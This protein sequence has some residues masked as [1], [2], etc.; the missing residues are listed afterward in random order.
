MNE[1]EQILRKRTMAAG[2]VAIVTGAA[3]RIG[4]E[5][6]LALAEDGYAVLVHYGSSEAS[7]LEVVEQ[8][9]NKGGL[10]MT[11]SADLAEPELSATRICDAAC[12][13]GSPTLLINS[14][15]VFEDLPLPQI[16]PRHCLEHFTVNAIA[17]ILLAREFVARLPASAAGQIISLLDWRALHPPTDHLVYTASKAALASI[18]LTLAQ[19]LAPQI[20]V[21]GIALGAILAPPG[22]ADWHQQRAAE[23]I[24][25]RRHGTPRDVVSALRFLISNDFM[26]GEI[27]QLTG[28][29]HL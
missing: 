19:Q 13:L 22:R 27:L 2:G 5:I 11:V 7:A 18:T 16:S 20:R 15:A 23:Q 12:E 8:I 28:G 10:A 29:E 4:R 9:R 24:P 6:A 25:L 26:S 17:P 14:A 1:A 3:R 21:N